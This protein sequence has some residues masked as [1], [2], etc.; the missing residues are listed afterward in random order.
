MIK[1]APAYL[2]RIFDT[3][4][5]DGLAWLSS[6]ICASDAFGLKHPT[7]GLSTPLFLLVEGLLWSAQGA[8]SG[9]RTYFEATPVERQRAMLGALEHQA[10]PEEVLDNYRF[11]ME[12]W[13]DPLRTAD[14]DR[15]IDGNDETVARYLWALVRSHRPEI[16]ALVA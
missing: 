4:D 1:V 12:V 7:Y 13:R 9:V 6:M 10:A 15:W 3:A 16:E 2:D 14:L 11:G 8:R 5:H